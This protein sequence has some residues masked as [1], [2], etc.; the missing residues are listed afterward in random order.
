MFW[1][2]TQSNLSHCLCNSCASVREALEIGSAAVILKCKPVFGKKML[3]HSMGKTPEQTRHAL[4]VEQE[5]AVPYF[6]IHVV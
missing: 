3:E 4:H 5:L 6:C 2:I 1:S